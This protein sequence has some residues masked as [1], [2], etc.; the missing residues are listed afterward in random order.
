VFVCK[1]VYILIRVDISK[2]YCSGA[3]LFVEKH[4][5]KQ[6]KNGR[7]ETVVFGTVRTNIIAFHMRLENL[8]GQVKCNN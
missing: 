8:F 1:H 4:V 2:F 3:W 6:E 7:V 5:E